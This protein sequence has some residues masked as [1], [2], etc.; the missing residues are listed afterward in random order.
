MTSFCEDSEKKIWIGTDGGGLNCFDPATGKFTHIKKNPADN[1]G[2]TVN[3]VMALYCDPEDNIWIGT[4]NGGLNIYNQKTKNFRHYRF[5][6]DY[7]TTI[8]SDHPWGFVR[9]RWGNM[10][11]ATVNYGLNLM[12][13]GESKFIRYGIANSATS[14]FIQLMSDEL[15]NMFIDSKDRLWIGSE[16]GLEMVELANVDFSKP[17]PELVFK[18]F[19][20]SDSVNGI[21]DNRISYINEDRF[22]NIWVGTKGGGINIL[23]TKTW[24]FTQYATGQ[25]LPHNIVDGILFDNNAMRGLAQITGCR[26]FNPVSKQFKNYTTSDG[27]QSNVFFKTEVLRP[28]MDVL[29]WGN[30]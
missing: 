13:P 9:D 26:F 29:F 24:L 10:W 19:L 23:D 2:L 27:L 21:S 8:S 4:Y 5:N 18:H 11:V 16:G 25:G 15:T 3:V 28:A 14:G 1:D 12:K 20:Q 7:T 17:K 6:A 30:Q 22:G